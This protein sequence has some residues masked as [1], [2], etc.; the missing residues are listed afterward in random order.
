MRTRKALG[1]AVATV[2]ALILLGANEREIVQAYGD[3]QK[4]REHAERSAS[5]RIRKEL[6]AIA[7]A[8]GLVRE[9]KSCRPHNFTMD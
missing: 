6:P 9:S 2:D 1:I 8:Y 4:A 5:V 3:E 7:A